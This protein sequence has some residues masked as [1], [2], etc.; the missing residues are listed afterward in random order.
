MKIYKFR[1]CCLHSAE[2]RVLKDKEYL[3]LTP[4]TFDVLQL[5]IE[6]R[7]EVVTKDEILGKVWNGSF[8]EEGNL[9]VHISKLRRQLDENKNQAFI[10]TVQG[11][12]YR[13]VAPVQEITQSDWEELSADVAPSPDEKRPRE[14]IFD[15]IAVMPLENESRDDEIEYLTDGLTESFINSLSR[16]PSLKVIARNTVFR[17]KDKRI[18][19]KSVGE[20]LG[21]ATV[22][23]G[24][25]RVIKDHLIIGIEL[26]KTAD[27]T[28]LWG[29][30][31]NRTFTDI[32]EIQE[33]ILAEVL[34]SLKSE[35]NNASKKSTENGITKS[36]ESYRLYLKGKY[37]L[38]KW[39]ENNIYKAIEYFEQSVFY[40]P[41]NVHS[42]VEIIECYYLLYFSDYLGFSD[43]ISKINRLV[44][45]VS[46][47]E[48]N[49]DVVQAM[50]GTKKMYFD[51]KFSEAKK[52]FK[53]ALGLNQNCLIARH[54]Y[55]SLLLVTGKFS[56]ALQMLQPIILADPLSLVSYK[57]VSRLFYR[58][59][60]FEQ[61]ITY[62]KNVLELEPADY[63]ALIIL[64]A[65]LGEMGDYDEA[66]VVLQKSINLQYN[67]DTLCTIG[68]V[69]A[70][71]GEKARAYEVIK[72]IESQSNNYFQ[73]SI[74]LAAIYLALGER[75]MAYI[76]LDKAYE[77]H[78]VDIVA[79]KSNPIWSTI[80]HETRFKNLL[81]K[82]GLPTD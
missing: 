20:T 26:T 69:N 71:K 64:G 53:L 63:E 24:R 82:I 14:W 73:Y 23:T 10:E 56:E 43:A 55:S 39:T 3:D 29:T 1:N 13:F 6:T 74:K 12:G 58:M 15:S 19:A 16:L 30:H 77:E 25:I 33:S 67:I 17:Y 28:Q 36:P 57:R 46:K 50:F 21:V 47:L 61:A 8:V 54:R 65:A 34:E 76:Y 75:E 80:I 32:F 72:Q 81:M 18:D 7:G 2:R 62:V 27:G 42:Y 78:D 68:Y 45:V 66:L 40:D 41:L 52:H 70:R 44:S 9:A 37:L 60:R 79:L 49:I 59:G 38:E 5:M 48:Q 11:S 51:W 35:I 31:F 22:L 4:K